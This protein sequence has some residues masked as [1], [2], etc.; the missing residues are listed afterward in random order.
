MM[1]P[2]L[3]NDQLDKLATQELAKDIA[4]SHRGKEIKSTQVDPYALERFKTDEEIRLDNKR[5]AN[6]IKV[7]N[8]GGGGGGNKADK[9]NYFE[10]AYNQPGVAT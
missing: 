8:A 2:Q 6:K 7:K 5:T 10:I 9:F 3:T 4:L 1:N